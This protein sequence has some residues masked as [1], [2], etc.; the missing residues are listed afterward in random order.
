[1]TYKISRRAFSKT[2]LK[3]MGSLT[4]MTVLPKKLIKACEFE[5]VSHGSGSDG[6]LENGEQLTDTT[7]LI[8]H[9]D[10]LNWGNDALNHVIRSAADSMQA[11]G[12]GPVGINHITKEGGGDM[13]DWGHGTHQNATCYDCI[14]FGNGGYNVH[15]DSTD[16]N[17]AAN[18]AFVEELEELNGVAEVVSGDSILIQQLENNF[19]FN[20]IWDDGTLY[21]VPKH[22]YHMHIQLVKP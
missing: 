18:Y 11:A 22:D 9:S 17:R 2:L 15:K 13:S 10:T 8:S 19:N 5:S 6:W 14:N 3:L 12:Y 16:Y 1:M 4:V 21:G 20:V 7:N